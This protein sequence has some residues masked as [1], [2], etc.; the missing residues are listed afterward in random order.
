MSENLFNG[1]K[2]NVLWNVSIIHEK[3]LKVLDQHISNL[4][5]KD[6]NDQEIK[7]IKNKL[8]DLEHFKKELTVH[9]NNLNNIKNIIELQNSNDLSEKI[10][11]LNNNKLSTVVYLNTIKDLRKTIKTLKSSVDDLK[12]EINILKVNKSSLQSNSEKQLSNKEKALVENNVK[13]DVTV[14]IENIKKTVKKENLKEKQKKP[15]KPDWLKYKVKE[16]PQ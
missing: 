10:E 2:E 11:E 13:D 4:L 1:K 3:R 7:F 14:E 5:D 12:N 16:P 9:K 15:D 8:D 6:N